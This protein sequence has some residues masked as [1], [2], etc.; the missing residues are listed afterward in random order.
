MNAPKFIILTLVCMA[1]YVVISA[2]FDCFRDQTHSYSYCCCTKYTVA[3]S[4][5]YGHKIE[6]HLRLNCSF[7]VL[8]QQ[9]VVND[10]GREEILYEYGC[11]IS[12]LYWEETY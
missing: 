10:G 2:C 6:I 12:I 11:H 3:I 1:I 9:A 7:P 4:I 5:A 8:F